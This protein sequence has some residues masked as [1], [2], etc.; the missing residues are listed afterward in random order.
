[1]PPSVDMPRLGHSTINCASFGLLPQV[2]LLL[3]PKVPFWLLIMTQGKR[4][5][6]RWW[7][8]SQGSLGMACRSSGNRRLLIAHILW[9]IR[10]IA[11]SSMQ[12]LLWR[13]PS[14]F[15]FSDFLLLLDRYLACPCGVFLI[16]ARE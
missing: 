5:W 2:T 14:C 8:L 15:S 3:S 4:Q 12:D 6:W 16:F 9:D 10:R 1:M 13:V 11:R 7:Q